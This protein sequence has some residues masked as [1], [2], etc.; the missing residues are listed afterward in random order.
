MKIGLVLNTESKTT[1]NYSVVYDTITHEVLIDHVEISKS[2]T[3]QE[4]REA[5]ARMFLWT[6]AKMDDEKRGTTNR[7]AED[8][9]TPEEVRTS[10]ETKKKGTDPTEGHSVD[11]DFV[12]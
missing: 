1:F 5:F 12:R 10:G 4:F 3:E 11:S 6:K 7:K 2:M 8:G 9:K